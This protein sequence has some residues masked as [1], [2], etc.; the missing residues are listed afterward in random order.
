MTATIG[1]RMKQHDTSP[2]LQ[3]TITDTDA[4]TPVN[5]TTA[6]AVKVIGK[7]NGQVVFSRVATSVTN[8]GVVTMNWQ[9]ADT[10]L[11]GLLMVE[12]EI[13]WPDGTV[14]TMPPTGHLYVLIE[15]DLG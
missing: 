4:G 7:L 12:F 8:N 13:T 1:F 9:A 14:Q 5:L 3:A 2:S 6:S 11:A 15:P 10:A